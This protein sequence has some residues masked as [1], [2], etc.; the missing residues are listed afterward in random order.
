MTKQIK[1]I[2]E[3]VKAQRGW[4]GNLERING[5][6]TMIV[7]SELTTEALAKRYRKVVHQYY[8]FYNDGDFPRLVSSYGVRKHDADI[9]EALETELNTVLAKV[10]KHATVQM[11]S[12]LRM[13]KKYNRAYMIK[14]MAEKQELHGLIPDYDKPVSWGSNQGYWFK[15]LLQTDLEAMPELK[16]LVEESLPLYKRIDSFINYHTP[17]H[18]N[19]VFWYVTEQYNNIEEGSVKMDFFK[20]KKEMDQRLEQIINVVNPYLATLPEPSNIIGEVKEVA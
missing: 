7:D 19:K 12:Q 4:N 10:L 20:L 17:E 15:Q 2:Q 18:S 11:R 5:L 16:T 6:C 1:Q 13:N 9:E 14:Q 3:N 8:R